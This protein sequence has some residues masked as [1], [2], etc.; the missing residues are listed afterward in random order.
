MNSIQITNDHKTMRR[1][2]EAAYVL[3]FSARTGDEEKFSMIRRVAAFDV[4][5]AVVE[6]TLGNKLKVNDRMLGKKYFV[7]EFLYGKPGVFDKMNGVETLLEQG[8]LCDFYQFK[9]SGAEC[10]TISSSGDRVAGYSIIA[11][12]KEELVQSIM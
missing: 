7:G 1:L 12:T 9:S 5:D 4:V 11:D 8:I 10:D 3:E 6:L 2:G